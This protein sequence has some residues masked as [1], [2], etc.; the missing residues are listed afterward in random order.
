MTLLIFAGPGVVVKSRPLLFKRIKLSSGATRRNLPR[1][2]Y[3]RARVCVCARW[4]TLVS[5]GS[6][7]VNTRTNV[8][9][10][11]WRAP[12]TDIRIYLA[13]GLQNNNNEMDTRCNW[14][15]L[16][17][18]RK[19]SCRGQDIGNCSRHYSTSRRSKRIEFSPIIDDSI[20]RYRLH[21]FDVLL[22]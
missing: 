10:R 13:K 7:R 15:E 5:L 16:T 14:I 17:W 20:A 4:H 8:G 18:N 12:D 22:S 2:V 19:Y 3:L 9:G 21:I 6:L 1:S 11:W